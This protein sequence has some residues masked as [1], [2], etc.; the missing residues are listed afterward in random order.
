MWSEDRVVAAAS[1]APPSS[2]TQA[3]HGEATRPPSPLRRPRR[4]PP[5]ASRI[6]CVRALV[7]VAAPAPSPVALVA[8]STS[9]ERGVVEAADATAAAVDKKPPRPRFAAAAAGPGRGGSPRRRGHGAHGGRLDTIVPAAGSAVVPAGARPPDTL[10]APLREPNAGDG[11]APASR[12]RRHRSGRGGSARR[13]SR[14]AAPRHAATPRPAPGSLRPRH[15]RCR[16]R[17]FLVEGRV[18]PPARRCD[19]IVRA[20]EPLII[21]DMMSK[22]VAGCE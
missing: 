7:A 12:R 6:G 22:G 10:P 14:R 3:P 13:S 19:N 18:N 5:Q 11:G 15:G 17:W 9:T 21:S 4:S 8:R 2:W 20:T 16:Q 1:T